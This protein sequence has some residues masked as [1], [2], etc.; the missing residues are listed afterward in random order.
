M[1]WKRLAVWLQSVALG[2]LCYSGLILTQPARSQMAPNAQPQG[3]PSQGMQNQGTPVTPKRHAM[4][5]SYRGGSDAMKAPDTMKTPDAMTP[6]NA[7][8]DVTGMGKS[9]VSGASRS[10][11][12]EAD[13]QAA[14]SSGKVWVNTSTGVYHKSGKWYGTTKSGKFMTEEEATKA[15]YR[16]AKTEHK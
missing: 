5:P 10:A 2:G 3:T 12:S 8:K 11:M 4:P 6:P 15:G 16:P 7:V 13:I 14:R 1:S 9:T